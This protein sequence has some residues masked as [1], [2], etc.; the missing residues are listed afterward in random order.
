M[1]A[2]EELVLA[3]RELLSTQGFEATSPAD[4]QRRAG[5]GQGSFYHHFAGK[6]DLAHAAL[7][8]LAA[9]MCDELD[10]LADDGDDLVESYLGLRRNA[11]A[12]CRMG[13]MCMEG[14]LSDDRIRVPIAEYFAHVRARLA[15]AFDD[16]DLGV[17][18][19]AMADL[20]LAAV[21]GA[22]V[23]SRAAGDPSP[24]VNATSALRQL[25]TATHQTTEIR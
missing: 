24:M 21:Q 16:L 2:R 25:I 1:N 22:Y 20:A 9:D 7:T 6:A 4:I 11:L 19:T 8:E 15:A 5:V 13:R 18:P 17:D 12:G 14:A 23:T 10:R 3:T